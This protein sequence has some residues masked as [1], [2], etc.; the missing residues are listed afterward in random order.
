MPRKKAK[1]SRQAGSKPRYDKVRLPELDTGTVVW[2]TDPLIIR[3]HYEIDYIH[4]Y[5]EDTPFFLGLSQGKLMG[6]RCTHCRYSFATPRAYC[7]QCG[8]PTDWQR[9]VLDRDP[10]QP[11][12]GGV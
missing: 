9:G 3:A 2:H 10:V 8:A 6:S 7:M 11:G 4:S 1:P 12:P 5:A